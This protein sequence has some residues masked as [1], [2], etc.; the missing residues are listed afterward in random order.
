MR[1]VVMRQTQKLLLA[2]TLAAAPLAANAAPALRADVV[3]ASDIVRIGDLVNEA[4]EFAE[5]PV[6][7]APDL[8][9]VGTVP[10]R[11]VLDALR[12]QGLD[13][14]DARGISAVTVTRASHRFGPE[15][16]EQRI[17]GALSGHPS[18][19]DPSQLT[20]TFDR[21][22]RALHVD[23][24]AT[25]LNVVSA[26]Y[27]PRTQRFDVT[28]SAGGAAPL[29]L[30]YTGSAMATTPVA[31]LT[32]PVGRGDVIRASDVVVERRP[33]ATVP[34][35]AIDT[36]ERLVGL[37]A[38]RPLVASQ[39]VR[40]GDLM[41]PELVR[42]NETVTLTYE[43]AGLLL[44]VRGKALDSGAEGDT[45]NVINIQSKRTVQGTVVGQGR[46]SV[47]NLTPQIIVGER[48]VAAPASATTLTE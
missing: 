33:R 9:H 40:P 3:I 48:R 12:R 18:L 34:S 28:L 45:V 46:V 21:E 37:A 43:A 15:E 38:R 25:V 2:L 11:Q 10:T 29:R 42:Q 24:A 8:G 22:L 6:F 17:A 36:P 20:V 19:G 4:G 32:R 44:S 16:V 30:R 14:V 26:Y 27:D 31:V 5:V 41:K 1:E 7:R 47:A 23:P 35:G 13:E 39:P